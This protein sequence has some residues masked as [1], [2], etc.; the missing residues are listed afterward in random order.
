M[1]WMLAVQEFKTTLIHNILK[2]D[3]E[4]IPICHWWYREVIRPIK[5][6]LDS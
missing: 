5:N 3:K 1:V 6:F 4:Y 2:E